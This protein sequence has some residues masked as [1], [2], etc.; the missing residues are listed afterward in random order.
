MERA[1]EA[2]NENFGYILDGKEQITLEQNRSP[3]RHHRK[4]S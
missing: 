2:V 3:K 4:D 1:I